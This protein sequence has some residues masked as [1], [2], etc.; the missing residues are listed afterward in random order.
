MS[1]AVDIKIVVKGV[2]HT[3]S[4]E[5]TLYVPFTLTDNDPILKP[6]VDEQV[7]RFSAIE[8]IER[9]TIKAVM[10]RK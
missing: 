8:E 7:K 10:V 1:N 3:T 2:N 4:F 9:I 6:L 5:E